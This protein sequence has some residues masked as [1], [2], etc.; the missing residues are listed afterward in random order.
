MCVYIYIHTSV[1]LSVPPHV[2]LLVI[3]TIY[4]NT[5]AGYPHVASHLAGDGEGGD[6]DGGAGEGD[7]GLRTKATNVESSGRNLEVSK[8]WGP[9]FGSPYNKDHSVLGAHIRAPDFW[10]LPFGS[11]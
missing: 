5:Q 10:K 11:R 4:D 1:S 9:L 7:L 2:C 3:T 8:N 6:G